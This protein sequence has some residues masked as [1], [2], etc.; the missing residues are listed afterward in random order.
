MQGNFRKCNSLDQFVMTPESSK[1]V[2]MMLKVAATKQD[3]AALNKIKLT[4][5]KMNNPLNIER[6]H[7]C[8]IKVL[9]HFCQ[10][11]FCMIAKKGAW[12]MCD[13]KIHCRGNTR[14]T[15]FVKCFCL[16]NKT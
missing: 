1:T 6:I 12:S 2:I 10:S 16:A 4:H 5:W 15:T 9:N 3:L 7:V 14:K 13:K 11:C 8:L